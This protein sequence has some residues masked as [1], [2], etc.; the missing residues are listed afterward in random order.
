MGKTKG[1]VAFYS[2]TDGIWMV[3]K[4]GYSNTDVNDSSD[5]LPGDYTKKKIGKA[6]VIISKDASGGSI[7]NAS[8]PIR[9]EF[10]RS[11]G[12]LASSDDCVYISKGSRTYKV[13]VQK[14][15]GK[16]ELSRL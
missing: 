14:L 1:F 8:E 13:N 15:T 12:S 5:C 6:G 9:F 4:L 16:V 10:K 3:E 11:D 2:D 7:P